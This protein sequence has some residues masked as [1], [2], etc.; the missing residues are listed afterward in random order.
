MPEVS[1]VQSRFNRFF[2]IAFGGSLLLG[3]YQDNR[4]LTAVALMLLVVYGLIWL[5]WKLSFA[6]L[7]SRLEFSEIRAFE[8]EEVEMRII[9]NN[10]SYLPVFWL[11]ITYSL[12]FPSN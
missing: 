8:G 3:V 9:T 4:A 1:Q 10:R 11:N 2:L 12:P 5:W 6:G 7:T